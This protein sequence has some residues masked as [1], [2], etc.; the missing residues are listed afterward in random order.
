MNA[1]KSI[2]NISSWS[3]VNGVSQQTVNVIEDLIVSS[4]LLSKSSNEF[5]K[6][7]MEIHDNHQ[8]I[9]IPEIEAR[10][11]LAVGSLLSLGTQ[12]YSE[13]TY[14]KALN[15]ITNKLFDFN[16]DYPVYMEALKNSNHHECFQTLVK[17][18]KSTSSSKL[19][20]AALQYIGQNIQRKQIGYDS[21]RILVNI[22]F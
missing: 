5:L 21:I 12:N 16:K 14:K 15:K 22:C 9:P 13:E 6:I 4:Q 8:T 17:T 19:T 10:S 2:L 3:Q 7:I 18:I 20:L 1:L 11:I